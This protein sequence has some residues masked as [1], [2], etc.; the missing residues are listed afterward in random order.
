MIH[1]PSL[2][3]SGRQYHVNLPHVGSTSGDT[4]DGSKAND[5]STPILAL[6]EKRRWA[7]DGQVSIASTLEKSIDKYSMANQNLFM[8]IQIH[9]LSVT[10]DSLTGLPILLVAQPGLKFVMVDHTGAIS[11]P[12]TQVQRN[13]K[14]TISVGPDTPT[15]GAGGGDVA[16]DIVCGTQYVNGQKKDIIGLMSMDGTSHY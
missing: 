13:P 14:A 10:K 12:L 3:P 11:E 7:L 9:C 5:A 2:A 15:R 1:F 6:V 16:T 8:K 4:Q